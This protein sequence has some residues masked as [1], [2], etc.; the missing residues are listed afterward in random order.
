MERHLSVLAALAA[1][2]CACSPGRQHPQTPQVG[3]MVVHEQP[4]QLIAELPGRTAPYAVS[5]VEPEVTGIIQKRL[6]V[7][8]SLV[9]AGQ[10]LYQID[11]R[12]YQA[13][14][15]QAEGQLAQAQAN[16]ADA[17]I[18]LKRYQSLVAQNAI[19]QQTLDTQ[20]A[21]VGSDEGIVKADSANLQTAKINLGW[22][23]VLA[24]ITG[25]IGASIVTPGALVNANQ[26]T[27]LSV[28]STLDPIYVDIFQSSDEL[29]A[30]EHQAQKG[31]VDR[32]E[33]L[34]AK[35][36]V[37]LGDG[38]TYPLEGKL[39]FTDVTVDQTTGAVL[40]RALFPNPDN[41][42]LPGLYVR[43]IIN[44]GVDPHGILVPQSAVSRNPKGDP[45]VLV[46]DNQNMTRLRPISTG[47]M[48]GSNW[49]VVSGLK[50]GD[51]VVVKG[52]MQ[53]LVVVQPDMKVVPHLAKEAGAQAN[54]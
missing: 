4:V 50:G 35:V 25:R 29:L 5:N 6:F 38:T 18:D 9:K 12:P 41:I 19:S 15:D 43:A 31:Q 40:L 14:L 53:G 51:K 23:R 42:L 48:I 27:A 3:Y 46:V 7:E 28:I 21:L 54:N 52:L 20:V 22:T 10:P 30:L 24:P 11:P 32:N 44:E 34:T 26:T 37:K 2:L 49:Q 33:P 16:L 8:G 47:R 17:R 13:A 45:E 1:V 36:T 39:E